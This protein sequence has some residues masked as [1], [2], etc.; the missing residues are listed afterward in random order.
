M[1]YDLNFWRYTPGSSGDHQS[2]YERLSDGQHVEDLED[3]PI[4]EIRAE[5]ATAFSDGWTQSGPD[6]WECSSA[7]FQLFTTPQFL[8]VDCYRMGGEDMNRFIDVLQRYG[9]PLYDP[10]VGERFVIG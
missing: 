5:I 8:R 7:A 10:R 1:S 9:C 6:H 4:Q 2:V 3:L